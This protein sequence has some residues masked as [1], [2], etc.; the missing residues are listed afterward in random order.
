MI[1]INTLSLLAC[2]MDFAHCMLTF[3]TTLLPPSPGV[4]SVVVA[5]L[6]EKANIQY[7]SELTDPSQLV[8]EIESLGYGANLISDSEGYQQ[9]KIDLIVRY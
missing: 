4:H 9:G 1:K 6:A 3:I 5:L 2:A 7:D 8:G